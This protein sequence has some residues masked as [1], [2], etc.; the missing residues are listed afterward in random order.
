MSSGNRPMQALAGLIVTT[1]GSSVFVMAAWFGLNQ[2]FDG[3]GCLI[4]MFVSFWFAGSGFRMVGSSYDKTRDGK[5]RALSIESSLEKRL[6][7]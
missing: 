5:G 4:F 3:V 6:E 1:A 7:I 2:K